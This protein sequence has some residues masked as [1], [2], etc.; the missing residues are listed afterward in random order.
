M[1]YN[2]KD[3]TMIKDKC[4]WFKDDKRESD[5]QMMSEKYKTVYPIEIF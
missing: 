2:A 5:L 4:G 3:M 1:E